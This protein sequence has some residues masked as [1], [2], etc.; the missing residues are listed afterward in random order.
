MKQGLVNFFS[1]FAEFRT[2]NVAFSLYL[3]RVNFVC[4]DE[5]LIYLSVNRSDRVGKAG[6]RGRLYNEHARI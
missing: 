3:H 5:C 4:I 1:V 2:V 6:T